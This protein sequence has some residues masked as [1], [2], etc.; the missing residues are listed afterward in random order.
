LS[1]EL[2]YVLPLRWDDERDPSA[3][4][5]YLQRLSRSVE[6][7]VVDGSPRDIFKAHHGLWSDLCE[8][9]PPDPDLSFLNGKVDGVFTGVRRAKWEAVVIADD[10]VRYNETALARVA[11]LLQKADLVRPQNYFDPMPWHALWDSARS[12]L[13]RAFGGDFP[14]TLGFRKSFFIAMGG[15]DGDV[16]FENLELIRTVAAAG[17]SEIVALDLFVARVPPSSKGFRSQRVRQAFDDLAMPSRLLTF[18]ALLPLTLIAVAARKKRWIVEAAFCSVLVAERGRRRGGGTTVFPARASLFAPL[19]LVERAFCSWLAL[20][21]RIFLGGVR[22]RRGVIKMASSPERR[23][24]ARF[25]AG[26]SPA[27]PV[28]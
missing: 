3:L 10:D 8:H 21:S 26:E 7:I 6:V 20:G 23:L 5:A 1:L 11:G 12:L 4:T 15:Y 24:K 2:S 18:L 25:A 13:N 9:L 27:H 19:W 17:G 28:P 16:M 22:Y 14:G